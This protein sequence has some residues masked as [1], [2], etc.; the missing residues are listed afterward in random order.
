MR[1]W[2]PAN[3][4]APLRVILRIAHPPL[5]D[6]TDHTNDF[7]LFLS[8]FVCLFQSNPSPIVSQNLKSIHQPSTC[9]RNPKNFPPVF[10]SSLTWRWRW[11]WSK[12]N[13]DCPKSAASMRLSQVQKG[14]LVKLIPSCSQRYGMGDLVVSKTTLLNGKLGTFLK[15]P[16]CHVSSLHT[17]GWCSLSQLTP[18]QGQ[19][20]QWDNGKL[21]KPDSCA[22]GDLFSGAHS[23]IF[24][25]G[26]G[27]KPM[28]ATKTFFLQTAKQESPIPD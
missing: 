24:V 21:L 10:L 2:L 12:P 19:G 15:K 13:G 22:I 18:P 28:G 20:N 27:P 3:L 26:T 16:R 4:R 14:D 8:H 9:N 6:T 25:Q 5:H 1:P 23:W 7:S 11:Q 17:I